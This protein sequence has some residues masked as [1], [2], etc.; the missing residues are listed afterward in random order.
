MTDD[1]KNDVIYIHGR[2]G[3]FL[4][5]AEG[6]MSL[7][8]LEL[9]RSGIKSKLAE[10][11]RRVGTLKEGIIYHG[12]EMNNRNEQVFLNLS[13][14]PILGKLPMSELMMVVFEETHQASKKSDIEPVIVNQEN[15]K[16]PEELNQ[17]LQFQWMVMYYFLQVTNQE[18]MEGWTFIC[19]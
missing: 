16:T 12:L 9:A 14:K 5:P 19:R 17:E 4:E 13:I 10:G 7:N 18:V 11:I 6:K 2:I 1:R 15:N 8:I 3:Q